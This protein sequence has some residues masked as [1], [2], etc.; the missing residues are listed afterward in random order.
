MGNLFQFYIQCIKNNNK[1]KPTKKNPEKKNKENSRDFVKGFAF[2]MFQPEVHP[3]QC[4]AFRG[5]QGYIVIQTSTTIIPSG[6]TL[7]HIP[8]SL[9]PS[10]EIDSA[11]KDFTVLVS[12]KMTIKL[13]VTCL[14]P[15]VVSNKMTIEVKVIGSTPAVVSNKMTVKAK[16][17]GLTPAKVN[18]KMTVKVKVTGL[19]LA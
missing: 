17:T 12:N 15:A 7:E 3:G 2:N 16:V 8:K 11:P 1:K 18:N 5:S 13:K 6:F 4:W 19:T 14:T 10:G 9:A